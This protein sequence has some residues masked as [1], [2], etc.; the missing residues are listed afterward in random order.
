MR[1]VV[2]IGIVV[3]LT[4][5]TQGVGAITVYVSRDTA[6]LRDRQS[7]AG[8]VVTQVQRGQPLHV[9]QQR[10]RWF[11]VST[12]RGARGWIYRY[13]VSANPPA[14]G[15]NALALLGGSSSRVTL[16]ETSSASGIR[17]L[18]PISERQA[19]RRGRKNRDIQAVKQM[20]QLRVTPAALEQFL[21]Q[22]KLGEFQ[23]G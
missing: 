2:P 20:E 18:N 14:R 1:L 6:A 17:G 19:R 8:S 5:F 10:G 22:G 12:A 15:A 9:L 4:L 13:K 23:G 7:V 3:L 21:R 16:S 11:L